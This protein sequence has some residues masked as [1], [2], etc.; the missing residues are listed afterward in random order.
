[1]F[2]SDIT[3]AKPCCFPRPLAP[4]SKQVLLSLFQGTCHSTHRKWKLYSTR[5]WKCSKYKNRSTYL[6]PE[7]QQAVCNATAQFG[8][9]C[10]RNLTEYSFYLASRDQKFNVIP[11]YALFCA[12]VAH[13]F[14]TDA[15]GLT[16][17]SRADKPIING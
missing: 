14:S 15:P 17:G 10:L 16:M 12:P 5:K 1:M 2:L 11:A 9:N 4:H 7:A 6:T 13:P 3:A 8:S